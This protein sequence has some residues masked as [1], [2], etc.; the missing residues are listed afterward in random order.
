M[1][2]SKKDQVQTVLA[3]LAVYRGRALPDTAETR[4][5]RFAEIGLSSLTLA[6]VVV[7]LEERL[8]RPFEFEAFAGV[9][10]VGGLLQAVG[11]E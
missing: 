4:R 9:Q 5:L 2:E 11:L 6:S 3:L 7:E 1:T 8:D 10:T